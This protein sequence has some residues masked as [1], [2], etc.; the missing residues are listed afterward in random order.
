MVLPE[1]KPKCK[2]QHT[3]T[4]DKYDPTELILYKILYEGSSKTT[5]QYLLQRW[6]RKDLFHLDLI[7]VFLFANEY[8]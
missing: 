3:G 4:K 7:F 6:D 1:L 8:S 5:E 2:I